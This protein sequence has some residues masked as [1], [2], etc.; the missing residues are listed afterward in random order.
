[1]ILKINW[2]LLSILQAGVGK[3]FYNYFLSPLITSANIIHKTPISGNAQK[4]ITPFNLLSIINQDP[5]SKIP[6]RN[7]INLSIIIF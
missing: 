5:K 7:K 3:L 2:S 4:K 6:T 1:M